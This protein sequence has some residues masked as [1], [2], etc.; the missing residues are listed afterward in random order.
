MSIEHSCENVLY[1]WLWT[2]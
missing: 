1:E 2:S